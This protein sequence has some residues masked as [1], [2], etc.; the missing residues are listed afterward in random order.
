MTIDKLESSLSKE[1]MCLELFES[2]VWS[3]RISTTER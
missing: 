3:S 2:N 1:K